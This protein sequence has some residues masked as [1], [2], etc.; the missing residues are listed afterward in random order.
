MAPALAELG[1]P[2]DDI[3]LLVQGEGSA[4]LAADRGV[5]LRAWG[6]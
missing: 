3:V 1:H 6:G 5:F 4:V 2:L